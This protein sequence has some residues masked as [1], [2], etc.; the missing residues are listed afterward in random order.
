MVA[1]FNE[2]AELEHLKKWQ[3]CLESYREALIFGKTQL[4]KHSLIEQIEEAIVSV[5]KKFSS[6]G[7]NSARSNTRSTSRNFNVRSLNSTPMMD[8]RQKN[9]ESL[10]ED[11]NSRPVSKLSDYKS[12]SRSNLKIYLKQNRIQRTIQKDRMASKSLRRKRMTLK[13]LN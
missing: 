10:K 5:E 7:M 9:Y 4:P 12:S 3:S 2:A 8:K 11:E 13:I 1:K 6:Q